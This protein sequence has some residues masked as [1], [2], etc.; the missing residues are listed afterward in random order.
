[1]EVIRNLARCR[2]NRDPKDVLSHVGSTLFDMCRGTPFF[3]KTRAA[4]GRPASAAMCISVEPS[5][6]GSLVL[7]IILDFHDEKNV[8]S[9]G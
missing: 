9:P 1:M 6:N 7:E 4:S 2:L 3:M 8:R 5:W